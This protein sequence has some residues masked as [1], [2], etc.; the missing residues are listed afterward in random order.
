[1]SITSSIRRL[2][3]STRTSLAILAG[4]ALWSALSSS[5]NSLLSLLLLDDH[6]H[7]HSDSHPIPVQS[8]RGLRTIAISSP[9]AASNP[10]LTP[11]QRF[12]RELAENSG[13]MSYS[14]RQSIC[15]AADEIL[16]PHA[17]RATLVLMSYS[18]RRLEQVAWVMSCYRQMTGVLDKILFVWNN[19]DVDLPEDILPPG[20]EP[21]AV[22]VQFVKP[23]EN[24]MTNRFDAPNTYADENAPVILVDDDVFL[25]AGLLAGMMDYWSDG[26]RGECDEK[27][28]VGLDPRYGN[29]HTKKYGI[30]DHDHLPNL[31]IG[32]TMLASNKFFREYMKNEALVEHTREPA[33]ACEDLTFSLFVT[34]ATTY[35]PVAAR[36]MEQYSAKIKVNYQR[37]FQSDKG[38]YIGSRYDIPDYDGMS[39]GGGGWIQKRHDCVDWNLDYFGDTLMKTL[40]EVHYDDGDEDN[41][42]GGNVDGV[43][44]G[45]KVMEA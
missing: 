45:G 20:N 2:S 42:E 37:K 3:K 44:V 43:S 6:D 5:N 4:I 19:L 40:L 8:S 35:L 30:Y 15:P 24:W 12:L 27:C 21:N 29:P 18:P 10:N 31:V 41:G 23:K 16:V 11:F 36:S 28:V 17:R 9:S 34:N 26:P 32:K 1:M 33:V 25:T 14:D 39:V 22:P 38:E 7:D 13:D